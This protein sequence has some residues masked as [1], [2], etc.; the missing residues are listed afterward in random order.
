[1]TFTGHEKPRLED[2]AHHGVKGMHW[3]VR[4][5]KPR[6]T[7][8]KSRKGLK[9]AAV[10]LGSAAAAAAIAVGTAYVLS[11]DNDI[12]LSKAHPSE[13][14]KKFSESF[15]KEP[16]G[17]VHAARG[18]NRGFT[19]PQRGS[20]D[21][22]LKE[23][24]KAGFDDLASNS[25]KRYGDRQEKVAAKFDDPEGR[26]DFAGRPIEH[27]VM[28]PESMAQPVKTLS[29]V[30]STAWPLIKDTYETLYNG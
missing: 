24:A 19:F 22:P 27:E 13:T 17:I 10:I 8:E 14:G 6:S 1:M 23:Y 7:P 12:P 16:V 30:V 11:R 21:D 2:L 18:K 4:K 28:L 9:K 26:K 20:L 29:D 25:H 15:A 5:D 3:G